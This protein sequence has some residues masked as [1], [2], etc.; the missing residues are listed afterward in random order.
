M[1]FS[2]V[3]VSPLFAGVQSSDSRKTSA[4]PSQSGRWDHQANG[5]ICKNQSAGGYQESSTDR[6][7]L[8]AEFIH[9]SRTLGWVM[10]RNFGRN[11]SSE[12]K[13]EFV[14]DQMKVNIKSSLAGIIT[15]WYKFYHLK[16][17][18]ELGKEKYM[19]LCEKLDLSRMSKWIGAVSIMHVCEFLIKLV[20]L[21][22]LPQA[23]EKK[24]SPLSSA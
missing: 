22:K 24:S 3:S 16:I 8:T 7:A 5:Q 10:L 19:F 13:S 20:I 21:A 1:L 18:C 17:I 15:I 12:P 9:F 11:L 14:Y 6:H 2:P 4:G 23:Q